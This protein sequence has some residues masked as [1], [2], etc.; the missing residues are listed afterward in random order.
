VRIELNQ[1]QTTAESNRAVFEMPVDVV[2][3]GKTGSQ[4]FR[5]T[6]NRRSQTYELELDEQPT[7]IEVDPERSILR[8]PELP[9]SRLPGPTVFDWAAYPNPASNFIRVRFDLIEPTNVTL[10]LFDAAGRLVRRYSYGHFDAGA[11]L[12][13]LA[14]PG[15]LASGLYAV[16]LR[17][18]DRTESEMIAVVR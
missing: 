9:I 3:Y 8:D 1:T 16:Q 5:V 17:T 14:L 11:F 10:R 4:T 15:D 7:R 18:E 6:N 13:T 12:R 2:V